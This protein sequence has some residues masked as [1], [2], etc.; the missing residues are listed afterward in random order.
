[1]LDD[2]ESGKIQP[3]QRAAAKG[4]RSPSAKDRLAKVEHLLTEAHGAKTI[5]ALRQHIDAALDAITATSST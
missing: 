2:I 3:P 1:V 5:T 4:S